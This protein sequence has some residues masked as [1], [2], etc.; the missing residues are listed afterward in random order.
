MLRKYSRLASVT[1]AIVVCGCVSTPQRVDIDPKVKTAMAGCGGSLTAV[2]QSS[3]DAAVS[4]ASLSI[5]AGA[6]RSNAIKTALEGMLNSLP[7]AE[8]G[9]AYDTY[10]AC[11]IRLSVNEGVS[12]GLSVSVPEKWTLRAAVDR[13]VSDQ[14]SVAKYEGCEAEFLNGE[15]ASGSL[16]ALSTARL[17]ELLPNKL[18][19]GVATKMS[20]SIPEPGVC[21]IKCT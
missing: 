5:K 9:K 20:V 3:I 13:L 14:S 7:E 8:R 18:K 17:I 1:A 21:A 12:V 11:V 16:Q 10:L 4:K 2:N 15:L 6:S 19:V